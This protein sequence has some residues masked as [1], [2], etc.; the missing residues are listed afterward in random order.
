M[1]NINDIY[2]FLGGKGMH[3]TFF[4]IEEEPNPYDY[5]FEDGDYG[6]MTMHSA[7]YDFWDI[8]DTEM[9]IGRCLMGAYSE[10]FKV[11]LEKEEADP[12]DRIFKLTIINRDKF[13]K[14]LF[15]RYRASVAEL[16]SSLTL[17]M[18]SDIEG[19]E[20]DR[21]RNAVNRVLNNKM[22]FQFYSDYYGVE[23][24]ESFIRHSND[25][26]VYYITAAYDVH[27]D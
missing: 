4:V 13:I 8:S 21:L 22:G 11:E 24:P 2:I 5:F 19:V 3:T 23:S 12:D 1:K 10:Y 26:D 18:F 14:E 9:E 20:L 25:G 17:E 7:G 16:N 15:E 6:V 27:M